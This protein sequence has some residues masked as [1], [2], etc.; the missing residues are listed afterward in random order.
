MIEIQSRQVSGYPVLVSQEFGRRESDVPREFSWI[1]DSYAVAVGAR[2]P[3]FPGM[4][5]IYIEPHKHPFGYWYL[6]AR[7]VRERY[8][9]NTRTHQAEL[10]V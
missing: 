2:H 10:I 8:R 9:I 7:F 6:E 1:H 5:C 3:S 4:I